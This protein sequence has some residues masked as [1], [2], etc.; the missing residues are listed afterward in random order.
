MMSY[1]YEA[2]GVN[3]ASLLETFFGE[4]L[5]WKTASGAPEHTSVICGLL[6]NEPLTLSN[7]QEEYEKFSEAFT[8][9][10]Q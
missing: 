8:K 9:S 7:I 2:M 5:Q 1:S 4:S 3:V 6:T 10:S